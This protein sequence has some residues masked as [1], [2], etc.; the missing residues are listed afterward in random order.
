MEHP[1]KG[2]ALP[3]WIL[4][5]CAVALTWQQFF[6]DNHWVST[7]DGALFHYDL[8]NQTVCFYKL[9]GKKCWAISELE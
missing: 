7:S 6:P 8:R 2:L 3:A 1:L 4:A 5:A 9:H